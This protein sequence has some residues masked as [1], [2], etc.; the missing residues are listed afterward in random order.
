MGFDGLIKKQREFYGTGVTKKTGFRI[1]ALKALRGAVKRD[2]KIIAEALYAD[3]HR[4]APQA[5]MTETGM[6]IQ[7]LNLAIRK[8]KSWA[9][10]RRVPAQFFFPFSRNYIMPEP[11]GV[12]LVISPWNYPFF[13]SFLPLIAA[14]SAGNCC[15]LKPS[16]AAAASA[17]VISKIIGSCLEPGHVSVIEPD[18]PAAYEVLKEKFDYIFFTGGT[19]TGKKVL[20]SAAENI[21][22]VT[23]ELGGKCPCIVAEDSDVELAAKRVAAGK[24]LNAGQTCVAP[25]YALVH[26][27][28]R[29]RFLSALKTAIERMYGSNPENSPDYCRIINGVEYARIIASLEGKSFKASAETRYIAPLVIEDASAD[30]EIMKEEIFGPVLPVIS[31]D[32]V[33]EAVAFVNEREKPLVLYLFAKS[34]A[35]I[36]RVLASTSSGSACVNDTVVHMGN[37]C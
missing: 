20:A 36:D 26:K 5:Y 13:L 29:P 17:G 3:L 4:S 14:I 32:S 12:V 21:T 31:F 27:A 11:Y 35:V 19:E 1:Q 2:E 37:S 24:F 8:L 16:R 15:V 6:I 28:V 9:G 7:E 34:R 33:D 22:P 10:K 25:D 30:D 23:L 18:S